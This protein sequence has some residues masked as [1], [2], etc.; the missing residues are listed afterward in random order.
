M[1]VRRAEKFIVRNTNENYSFL[2]D[3]CF[4]SKNLY[5]HANSVIRKEF[6]ENQ[7]ILKYNTIDKILKHDTEYPDYRQLQA[8]SSQQTL[9]LLC[10]NWKAFISAMKSYSKDKSKFKGR[11]KPPKYLDKVK[12]RFPVVFT[13]QQIKVNKNDNSFNISSKIKFYL[14]PEVA[15]SLLSVCEIRV[16]PRL[17]YIKVEFIYNKG[18]PDTMVSTNNLLGID[19]GVNNL[20]TTA[21]INNSESIIIDGKGLKSIN[22]YYNKKLAYYKG[23]A[24]KEN[25]LETTKR[26][27]QL[28]TKRNFKVEN[29][30]H[31]ASKLIVDYAV[32]KNIDT[33]VIGY[34]K[35]WK[36]EV[37]MGKSKNQNFVMIPFNTL[38]NMI[39]YKAEDKG[40]KVLLVEES[41]TSGTSFLD[42]ETPTK[43]NYNKTRR[44]KRGLFKSNTNKYINADVN[45]AHQIL[46]KVSGDSITRDSVEG[47]VTN[48]IKYYIK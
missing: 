23:K 14:R 27:K 30:L 1:I 11:P 32:T 13:N 22:Q 19:L 3:L 10:R 42:N 48:P 8:Q 5:N 24:E 20:I 6:F 29:Y 38:V 46:K 43:E 26:I 15:N 31:R 16:V 35:D 9:R 45:S 12:G 2:D 33:I 44:I 18:I 47:S 7:I 37:S 25:K 21:R 41:Y 36:Q 34:N 40:I 39:T 4:K 28:H 17:N